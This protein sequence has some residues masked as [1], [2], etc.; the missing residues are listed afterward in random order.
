MPHDI[1]EKIAHVQGVEHPGTQNPAVIL[2]QKALR[3]ARNS[4]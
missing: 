1:H 3:G 2:E 4:L